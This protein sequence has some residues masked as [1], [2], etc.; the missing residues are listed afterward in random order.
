[1][2]F[3]PDD[4][5]TV[6]IAN[7]D[8]P[9]MTPKTFAKLVHIQQQTAAAAVLSVSHVEDPSRYG[10][11]RVVRD[12]KGRVQKIIE[13][14][15]LSP[16]ESAI[17]ECNAGSVAHDAQWLRDALAKVQQ[18]KT[19]EYY[20]TELVD[21]AYQENERIEV[22]EITD[23]A[24]AHGVNTMEHLDQAHHFLEASN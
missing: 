8:K 5:R 7:G 21:I 19:G 22:V 13:Q 12:G 4:A 24:E 15:V 18:S 10:Y 17:T 11:G 6:L 14:K 23:P 9:L 1:M 16:E 3:V 20:L 2:P